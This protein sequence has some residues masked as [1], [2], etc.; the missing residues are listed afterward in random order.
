MASSRIEQWESGLFLLFFDTVFRLGVMTIA[1]LLAI[2][3]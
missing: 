2:L 3:L 1:T